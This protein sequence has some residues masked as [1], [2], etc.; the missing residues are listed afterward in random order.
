MNGIGAEEDV[1]WSRNSKRGVSKGLVG[2]YVLLHNTGY[3][4]RRE[5]G[6]YAR[7]EVYLNRGGGNRGMERGNLN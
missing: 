5:I 2:V 7:K 1:D 6:G 3:W 4:F